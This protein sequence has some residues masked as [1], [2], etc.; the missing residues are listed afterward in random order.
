MR[1]IIVTNGSDY[2]SLE[3]GRPIP[4]G[5]R[6]VGDGKTYDSKEACQEWVDLEM[7]LLD[8]LPELAAFYR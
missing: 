8:S 3:V 2:G 5:F 7:Y 4:H 1:Y 6:Q